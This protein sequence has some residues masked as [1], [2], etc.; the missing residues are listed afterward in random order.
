[1]TDEQINKIINCN[2][3]LLLLLGY[4]TSMLFECEDNITKKQFEWFKQ[5]IDNIVYL[6]KPLPPFP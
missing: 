2:Y 4:A 6:D 5:S 1:M 3:R